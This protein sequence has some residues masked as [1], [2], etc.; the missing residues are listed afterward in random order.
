Y[1]QSSRLPAQGD[2]HWSIDPDN[3][4]LWRSDRKPLSSEAIRD[5]VLAIS[6]E[7]D[8]TLYG[9]RI[10]P[11][12]TNDYE[13]AHDPRARSIY[14]PAFR[15]SIPEILAAFNFTDPNTVTGQRDRGI[16]A[17]QGLL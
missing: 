3:R 8:S 9:S 2:S 14:L 6:G 4:L 10:R 5:G 11:G 15:N 17:Q 1:R 13:Y 7:L 12:T 16:I